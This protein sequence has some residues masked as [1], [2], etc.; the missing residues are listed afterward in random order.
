MSYEQSPT[1]LHKQMED[2]SSSAHRL[3][4]RFAIHLSRLFLYF[5][6]L[7]RQS[8]FLCKVR[9]SCYDFLP[10]WKL[11][12]VLCPHMDNILNLTVDLSPLFHELTCITNSTLAD[13]SPPTP[14]ST[15]SSVTPNCKTLESLAFSILHVLRR[16]RHHFDAVVSLTTPLVVSV[17]GSSSIDQIIA[18]FF[19]G[20]LDHAMSVSD[21]LCDLIQ[22]TE[23]VASTAQDVSN[24][25]FCWNSDSSV[26]NDFHFKLD[27]AQPSS[28]PEEDSCHDLSIV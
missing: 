11:A 12:L 6:T 18:S 5:S 10:V 28:D 3:L 19:S 27:P 13:S 15:V 14:S 1:I 20:W 22:A 21:S 7:E 2:A 16:I 17:V 8:Y 24:L 4:D 9:F 26:V 23:T 25:T